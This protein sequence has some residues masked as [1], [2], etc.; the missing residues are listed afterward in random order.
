MINTK[1][2]HSKGIIFRFVFFSVKVQKKGNSIH[3]EPTKLVLS[4]LKL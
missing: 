1:N 4:C 3:N 2:T